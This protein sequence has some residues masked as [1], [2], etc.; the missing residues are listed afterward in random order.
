MAISPRTIKRRIKSVTNTRKITKAM[1]LVAA[2]KMRKAVSSVL[3]TRPYAEAA[4]AAVGEISRTSPKDA[5]LHPLLAPR[6]EVKRVLLVVFTSDR[7]LCGGFNAQIIKEVTAFL[8]RNDAQ[9]AA[10]EV[11]VIAV[12][13]KG[14]GALLRLKRKIIAA[15]AGLTNAPR[16][17][18]VRTIA[19]LA[20][21]DFVAG[22]YDAAFIAFT[23]YRSA[24]VQKPL[25]RQ[26]LPIT[27]IGELGSVGEAVAVGREAAAQGTA[28]DYT[29]EP[30]PQEVLNQMLPRLVEA[31]VWQA[32]LESAASEH[33]ARM[34]AMRT[35]SDSASEMIDDLTLTYNQARQAGITREIAE[36]SSGKAALE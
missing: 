8:K 29:F 33:S 35:A 36:I 32:L 2:S 6:A 31:Q 34:M 7:G 11:D 14:Q 4:W 17:A 10:P 18:E 25:V 3:A 12:G 20:T 30:S 27:Q 23:D 19:D 26:L 16:F 13:K 1:E 9:A 15:F 28:I 5:A 22:T 24:L 21:R